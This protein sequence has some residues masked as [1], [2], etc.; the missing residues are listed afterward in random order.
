MRECEGEALLGD[1]AVGVP[2]TCFSSQ[3]D[4]PDRGG[5]DVQKKRPFHSLRS[6]ISVNEREEVR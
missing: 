4:D 3:R 5:R 1:G 6:S 2:H